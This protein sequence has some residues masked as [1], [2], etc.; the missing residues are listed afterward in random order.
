[1]THHGDVGGGFYGRCQGVG[2]EPELGVYFG[3]SEP[4]A[5]GQAV[6]F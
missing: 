5:D 3:A 1:M 2:F 6:G 4:R